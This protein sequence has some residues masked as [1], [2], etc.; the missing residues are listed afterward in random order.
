MKRT[1]KALLLS[2]A[3]VSA[4]P[5]QRQ[6]EKHPCDDARTQADLNVCADKQS[7]AADAE[8]N[9]VY[10][11]L[12]AKLDADARAKLK[13]A[14]VAWLKYRDAN[15]EYEAYGFEGGTM[16]PMVFS[17]CLERVTKARTAEL[18]EQLKDFEER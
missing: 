17:L 9:R 3:L 8:L 16:R 4:A 13:T 14:E 15:C 11:R 6:A 2:L 5:A 1:A 10:G 7:S 12:A 18:R